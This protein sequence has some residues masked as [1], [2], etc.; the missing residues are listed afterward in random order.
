MIQVAPQMKIL[1]AVEPVDFRGG[2]DA[3]A[4][5]CREV[6]REDPFSGVVFV[7]RNRS[8]TALK[9]LMYDSQGFWLATKRLS[10]SKFRWWPERRSSE[11]TRRLFAHELQLLLWNGNPDAA[12]TSP[13]WRPL[14]MAG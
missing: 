8:R 2:I 10:V 1:V 12:R 3:L 5:V 11:T 7:F 4:R 6:L 9:V 13:P 14:A